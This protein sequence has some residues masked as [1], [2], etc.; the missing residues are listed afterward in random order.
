MPYS[1]NIHWPGP[2]VPLEGQINSNQYK[3]FRIYPMMIY[4]YSEGHG[5]VHDEPTLFNRH[6]S[7]LNGL[8]RINFLVVLTSNNFF[9]FY[10]RKIKESY[11]LNMFYFG[12]HF[13]PLEIL[14]YFVQRNNQRLLK[15]SAFP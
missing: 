13:I 5:L 10:L 9:F 3:I 4:F 15:Y 14:F 1:Y 12:V 8:I 2:H 6:V 11:L 7:S